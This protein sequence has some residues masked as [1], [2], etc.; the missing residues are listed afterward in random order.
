MVD[1]PQVD[2]TLTSAEVEALTGMRLQWWK[3]VKQSPLFSGDS[4]HLEFFQYTDGAQPAAE[5][6]F[7]N[8][9]LH[10]YEI[11]QVGIERAVRLKWPA[12]PKV[13]FAVEGSPSVNGPWLPV[14]EQSLPGFKQMTVPA[15]RDLQFFR[16]R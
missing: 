13:D 8:L 5:A 6:T 3:D 15:N 2:P 4:F 10:T 7:D 16:L 14:N 12:S 9:E 1:T 11:P